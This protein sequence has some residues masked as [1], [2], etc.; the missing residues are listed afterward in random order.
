MTSVADNRDR[1][2]DV[3]DASW[4]DLVATDSFDVGARSVDTGHFHDQAIRDRLCDECK[5]EALELEKDTSKYAHTPA[6][7]LKDAGLE[8][9]DDDS[10]AS[11]PV[12][13]VVV[14]RY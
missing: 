4:Y 6:D 1:G 11:V 7:V 3:E 13:T 2:L 14:P 9:N 8:L 12:S 10:E 5:K